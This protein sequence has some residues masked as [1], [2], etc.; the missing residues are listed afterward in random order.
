[1]EKAPRNGAEVRMD[2]EDTADSGGPLAEALR[3]ASSGGARE[4]EE[5][6]QLAALWSS[7]ASSDSTDTR[8]LQAQITDQ[9]KVV[10]QAFRERVKKLIERDC[11]SFNILLPVFE[12]FFQGLESYVKT[13]VMLRVIGDDVDQMRGAGASNDVHTLAEDRDR[14]RR[15]LTLIRQ[16]LNVGGMAWLSTLATCLSN[17]LKDEQVQAFFAANE[18]DSDVRDAR[19]FLSSVNQNLAFATGATALEHHSE[20]QRSP[21]TQ[22]TRGDESGFVEDRR[23]REEDEESILRETLLA[24]EEM[25]KEASV[26]LAGSAMLSTFEKILTF[27]AFG[28]A[29]YVTVR[30]LERRL[31]SVGDAGLDQVDGPGLAGPT[32]ILAPI[33]LQTRRV[34][35][36]IQIIGGFLK[37]ARR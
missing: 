1:M 16:Q 31:G 22:H 23:S 21:V 14:L 33:L 12:G 17:F 27:A 35:A 5:M 24:I 30:V 7:I 3:V 18:N 13:G 11:P 29:T 20:S 25:H 10:F 8:E 4:G 34:G 28:V 2:M 32:V 19:S 37:I 26:L 6:N 36:V 15:W 9:V